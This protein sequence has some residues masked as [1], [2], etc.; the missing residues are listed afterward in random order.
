M[1]I[2]YNSEVQLSYSL[3]D[4][5]QFASNARKLDLG[6][7]KDAEYINKQLNAIWAVAERNSYEVKE[8]SAFI[9]LIHIG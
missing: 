3:D 9:P 7:K 6:G 8:R 5:S 2:K 1:Y 4:W